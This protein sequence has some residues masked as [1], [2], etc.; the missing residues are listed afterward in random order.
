MVRIETVFISLVALIG[1]GHCDNK[2]LYV[3]RAR[4]F[5]P[6]WKSL[7]FNI[8]N[9]ELSIWRP[10]TI[11][12][13][14]YPLG[15]VLSLDPEAEPN[16]NQSLMVFDANDGKV[17]A[18][19]DIQI[20]TSYG[21]L[22]NKNKLGFTLFRL[23]APAGYQCLGFVAK[24]GH[25]SYRNA[26][27]EQFQNYRCVHS[28]Y[29]TEGQSIKKVMTIMDTY[30]P[31]T[32]HYA[33][34][35]LWSVNSAVSP[36]D[37][38]QSET[39]VSKYADRVDADPT[40]FYVLRSGSLTFSNPLHNSDTPLL[41]YETSD[42]S[43]MYRFNETTFWFSTGHCCSL[44][45]SITAP[46]DIKPLGM[47]A[48]ENAD[49]VRSDG[50]FAP[51]AQP[52]D[53]QL[54]YSHKD[55]VNI[56]V[57]QLICPTSYV[58]LG[59]W[60]E[61]ISMTRCVHENFVTYGRWTEIDLWADEEWNGIKRPPFKL[62][63]A[64]P[65]DK[66]TALG[67]S[68]LFIGDENPPMIRAPLLRR[69]SATVASARDIV[70]IAVARNDDI[71]T[72]FW[73]HL[74]LNQPGEISWKGKST[75][76]NCGG[77][78]PQYVTN[79]TESIINVAEIRIH[80]PVET[81]FTF[82]FGSLS[83]YNEAPALS[84]AQKWFKVVKEQAITTVLPVNHDVAINTYVEYQLKGLQSIVQLNKTYDAFVQYADGSRNSISLDIVA[85]RKVLSD[86]TV[87]PISISCKLPRVNR[88]VSSYSST[89]SA[90]KT[91][92][93][94]LSIFLLVFNTISS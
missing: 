2:L 69:D 46:R 88:I 32:T 92:C 38:V 1:C 27:L 76:R 51:L 52:K 26:S 23:V 5:E 73:E 67:I 3:R 61:N 24:R 75:T 48:V 55:P 53:T 9:G 19:V 25:Y 35:T 4:Y 40:D 37:D 15:D 41:I 78:S 6:V 85:V 59:H 87:E 60:I 29:V 79:I 71:F 64:E 84:K 65:V 21:F 8:G 36:I 45:M 16:E 91:L 33:K 90:S 34:T 80:Y 70:Q 58:A 50:Y 39:F 13:D 81:S 74:N 12:Q 14:Y 72:E 93:L 54:I 49:Y 89:F 31:N 62:W 44:G 28:D 94:C 17:R 63:K 11:I 47:V 20:D 83:M 42:L 66:A 30:D 77:S 56:Q 18:P 57:Y 82:D 43:E 68:T 22:E 86:L 7:K 10:S